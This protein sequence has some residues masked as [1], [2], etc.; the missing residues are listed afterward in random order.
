MNLDRGMR[1]TI[2]GADEVEFLGLWTH[3]PLSL[4]VS[5]RLHCPHSGTL[6]LQSICAVR[7]CLSPWGPVAVADRLCVVPEPE[8]HVAGGLRSHPHV[9]TGGSFRPLLPPALDPLGGHRHQVHMVLSAVPHR[10]YPG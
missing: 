3:D 1:H 7:L 6:M 5:S 2:S 8:A 10:L 9:S 4:P